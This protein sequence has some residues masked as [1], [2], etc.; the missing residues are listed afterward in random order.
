M[1]CIFCKIANKEI[2][3]DKYYYEDDLVISFP[4]INPQAPFH[5][6]VIPKK[7]LKL[8]ETTK[9][10]IQTLGD[11]IFAAKEVAKDNS[12]LDGYRL[13][14]NNG[15]DAGQEVEHLHV[16]LLGGENLGKMICK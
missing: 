11:L 5:A 14:I 2:K 9:D 8:S 3:L 10:D 7:H 15:P 12:L 16:H 4:D 1:D 13:V 6:L